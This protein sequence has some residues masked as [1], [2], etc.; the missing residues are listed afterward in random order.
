MVVACCS[1]PYP[2]FALECADGASNVKEIGASRAEFTP[3]ST[4]G[5]Y[6]RLVLSFADARPATSS[7][8]CGWG[9]SFAEKVFTDFKNVSFAPCA[10]R[11]AISNAFNIHRC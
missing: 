11:Y 1:F 5:L 2:D 7:L 8:E 3:Q 4:T 6:G 9:Y 10:Q